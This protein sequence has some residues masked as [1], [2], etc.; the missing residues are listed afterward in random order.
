MTSIA[1]DRGAKMAC[2]AAGEIQGG[3]AGQRPF[4]TSWSILRLSQSVQFGGRRIDAL[5]ISL[6]G[7]GNFRASI[8]TIDNSP[9]IAYNCLE[10]L[11]NLA[12]HAKSRCDMISTI[13]II[14]PFSDLRI[15]QSELIES[16][17]SGPI[18]LSQRGRAS[19]VLVS[20]EDWNALV[21]QLEALDDALAVIEARQ[22]PEATISIEDY[23]AARDVQS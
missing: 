2:R 7:Q 14:R 4:A 17:N 12:F 22:R 20:I 10:S 19:A 9:K 21:E 16:L 1:G 18:V 3:D 13:P 8:Q 6:C 23:M 15:R 5:A 11:I